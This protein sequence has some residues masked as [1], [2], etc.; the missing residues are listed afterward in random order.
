MNPNQNQGYYNPVQNTSP[1][2][3]HPEQYQQNNTGYV[4]NA[5]KVCLFFEILDY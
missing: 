2:T 4:N 5:Y 3:Q 1:Q